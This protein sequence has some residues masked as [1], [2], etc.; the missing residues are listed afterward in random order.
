MTK[1]QKQTRQEMLVD[2][3][4][5]TLTNEYMDWVTKEK[6]P[7]YCAEELLNSETPLTKKQ[8]NWLQDFC[9]NWEIVNYG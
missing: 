1:K 7:H 5:I 2:L 6:L 9:L 4:N 3:A 8:R